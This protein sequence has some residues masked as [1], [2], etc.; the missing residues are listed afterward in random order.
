MI[1]KVTRGAR[2]SGLMT[3]LVG[4]GKS[5]EHTEQHLVAG[6]S[7]VMTMYGYESL[8][9]AAALEIAASLDAPRREFGV[10]VTRLVTR[11]DPD[12]GETFKERVDASVWHLLVDRCRRGSAVE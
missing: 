2:M 8:D 12:T 4:P 9:K 6:D 3:Y 7:A 11:V 10:N 1:A 5:N